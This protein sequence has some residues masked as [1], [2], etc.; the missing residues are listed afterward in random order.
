MRKTFQYRAYCNVRTEENALRW[1]E[2]CRTIYNLALEQRILLW[3]QS[4]KSISCYSQITQF[5]ELKVAFPEFANVN[6][7]CLQD[8]LERLD[9][10]FQGFFRR[11]KAGQKAGFPRFKSEKRY[12]SFTLKQLGWKIVES[13][14]LIVT[15]VGTFKLKLSRPIE[16]K[17]K[18]VTIRHS[19]T[20]KWFVSFS[21]DE[22]QPRT[23]PATN[24]TVGIDVGI[25][26]FAVDSDG[27]IVENPSYLR[28]SLKK[29][30]VLQRTLSRRVRGSKRREKTRIQIAKLYEKVAN[31]RKDFLNKIAFQYVQRYQ[32]IAVEDLSIGGML[33]NHYIALSIQD[34]SWGMFFQTLQFKAAEAGR[35]VLKVRP[36]ETS[37]RCSS[38]GENVPKKLSTRIHICPSCGIVLDRDYN[39][40]LNIMRRGTPQQALSSTLEFA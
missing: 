15:N 36:N 24:K 29:L 10:A 2:L 5:P 22:V 6:A 1:L 3:K 17:I 37:Q 30:R 12:D 26:H 38:C 4:K 18:T 25:K 9:K 32:Y 31:Q 39:A 16:G 11:I 19:S 8:V 7:Q 21:C 34:S 35:E 27:G 14:Y 13:K 40:A 33:H 28:Q 23:F 20:G